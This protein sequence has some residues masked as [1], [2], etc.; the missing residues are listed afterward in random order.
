MGFA[1]RTSAA[2][3]GVLI[4]F[5]GLISHA[6]DFGGRA[7]FLDALGLQI[8]VQPHSQSEYMLAALHAVPLAVYMTLAVILV[9]ASFLW[10]LVAQSFGATMDAPNLVP[11][12][13]AVCPNVP[14]SL[15]PDAWDIAFALRIHNASGTAGAAEKWEARLVHRFNKQR[16]L[17]VSLDINFATKFGNQEREVRL[18]AADSAE[19]FQQIPGFGKA[20]GY[21]VARFPG[22]PKI[23][24]GITV[25]IRVKSIGARWSKWAKCALPKIVITGAAASVQAKQIA[26]ATATITPPSVL[27]RLQNILNS[28]LRIN[29]R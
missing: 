15:E 10:P 16:G 7:E 8:S 2:A 4:F 17:W 25:Q 13:L 5:F 3:G 29:G 9:A 28:T 18:I 22:L 23:S 19:L 26:H 24:P 21:L 11:L 6:A 12:I 20:E 27:K 14:S 1:Q